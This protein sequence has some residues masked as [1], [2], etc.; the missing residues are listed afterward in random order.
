[1]DLNKLLS[2][3]VFKDFSAEDFDMVIDQGV[4]FA[5]EKLA[6]LNKTSDREGAKYDKATSKV[7]VPRDQLP[8][9]TEFCEN[10]WLAPTGNPEFGGGG[11]PG[12][13]GIA[14]GEAFVGACVTFMMTPGLTRSAAHVVEAFGTDEQ[15]AVY[16]E[17]MVTGKWAGTMCLTEPQAGSAVGDLK[18][19]AKPD[20]DSFLITGTKSFITSGDHDFTENIIHLVL[21]RIEGEPAGM[22]GV[23]L[24][25]VPKYLVKPDGGVGE[26]NDVTCGGIEEKMGIHGSPTCTLNFGENGKCRGYLIGEKN[27]GIVAM[28]QMMNEA[29]IGVGLQGMSQASAAYHEALDYAKERVQ[30]VDILEMKNVDAARVAIIKHPDV[31]RMLMTMKAYVEASRALLY[32]TAFYADIAMN[33]TNKN[34]RDKCK[35]FVE[36]LTP[37]CKAYCTD[38]AFK[39]TELGIQVLGGYGYCAEYPL[40]QYCRDV[41]IT[42]IYEGTNGIQAL[43]LLGRKIGM[44]G[45]MVLMSFLMELNQFIAANKKDEVLGKYITILEQTR[46]KLAGITSKLPKLGKENAYYPVLYATPFLELFGEIVCAYMLLEQAKIASVKLAAIFAERGAADD[47][48]KKAI[49][50]DSSEAAFYHNKIQTAAFFATNILPGV[51]AKEYAFNTGDVSPLEA[52]L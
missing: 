48:A 4:R 38:V 14:L 50:A 19:T 12:T 36:L 42:S 23:S 44:G 6:P 21:A 24:F 28:F 22:K 16:A 9:Y 1:L 52:I 49:V 26:F 37:V 15:K 20:G 30:G 13:V 27:K 18:T 8:V 33:S 40:E 39:V 29:R 17:K 45:G 43:D 10:G 51:F 41:K 34:D 7:L 35:G 47:A 11:F 2:L 25:I 3:E 31:R 32:K 5:V 46:D